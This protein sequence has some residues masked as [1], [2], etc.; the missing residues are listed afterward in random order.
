MLKKMVKSLA[1]SHGYE[2]RLQPILDKKV[3]GRSYGRVEPAAQFSPWLD[4]PEFLAFFE[5]IQSNTLVDR[6]R[7]HELWQIVPQVAHLPG[8]ILEVGVW[9]GGTGALIAHRAPSKTV[10]L[11]DTFAGVVKTGDRDPDY[12]GGEHSDTSLNIVK[13]LLAD[14]G[15][16]NA[17]TLVGIFPDDFPETRSYCLVH[18]DVDVYDSAKGVMDAVWPTLPVGGVVVFDDYGF[19]TTSGIAILVDQY[20]GDED[21]LVI[22][23]LNGHAVVIKTR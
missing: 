15:I 16:R 13:E 18:I 19:D 6:W 22:H 3:N 11:A 4:D 12:S 21:K 1:R 5:R 7:A 20:R 23:N 17:E 14:L 10:Y 2:V 9:R 8:D